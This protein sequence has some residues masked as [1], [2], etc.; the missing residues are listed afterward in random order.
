MR[1]IPTLFKRSEDFRSL[2]DEVNP[3]AA[4]VM[5]GEGWPTRKLDG[6]CA[7]VMDGML[8]KRRELKAG[9]D[10]PPGFVMVDH[11]KITGKTVGW[12]PI[13]SSP[14]DRYFREAWGACSQNDPGGFEMRTCELV[15]PK[16]Q[17]GVEGYPTH[18]LIFHD[19]RSLLWAAPDV[20]FEGLRSW[21]TE[22]DDVEGI[23]WHHPDG[24]MAKIKG[25]DFG[26][27]R[28]RRAGQ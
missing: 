8:F 27:K 15:G 2:I 25:R 10:E 7:A 19:D 12:V 26:I 1:K 21:L 16:V 4:W 24:R 22:N 9:A 3:L 13:G 20:T 17:G 18:Q 28:R 23:V 11:D 5:N 6:M 14:E